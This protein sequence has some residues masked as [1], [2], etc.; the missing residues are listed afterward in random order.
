[1]VLVR[2]KYGVIR[3]CVDFGNMNRTSEKDNYLIT[4]LEQLLQVISDSHMF[5][6]LDEFSGYNQVL[7]VELN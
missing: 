4:P 3:F 5:S 6:L 7:L 2:K 1:M